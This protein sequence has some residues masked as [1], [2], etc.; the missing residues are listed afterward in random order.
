MEYPR[1]GLPCALRYRYGELDYLVAFGG[2]KLAAVFYAFNARVDAFICRCRSSSCSSAICCCA[3]YAAGARSL[4]RHWPSVSA[5]LLA[6]CTGVV[7]RCGVLPPYSYA[8][9]AGIPLTLNALG[10]AWASALELRAVLLAVALIDFQ[11]MPGLPSA[12]RVSQYSASPSTSNSNAKVAAA[13]MLKR[14]PH[15]IC[16]IDFEIRTR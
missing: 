7:R 5:Q 8:D 4:F 10:E 2:C 15:Q 16:R 3:A 9:C 1:S 11:A 13:I 14:R 12:H 6:C